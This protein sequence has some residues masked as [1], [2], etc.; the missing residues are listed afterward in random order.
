MESTTALSLVREI[1]QETI[2]RYG[3]INGDN[4]IIHYDHDYA[5]N[6]GFPGTLAH[7]LMVMGY[8]AELG[9]RSL[10]DD[11]YTAGRLR[12]KWVRPVCPGDR[13][14]VSVDGDGRLLAENAEEPVM[15]GEIGRVD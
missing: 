4:D 13:I 9:A 14:T 12:V 7:G 6:R 5:V 11:W 1:T 8:A 10:G 3:E 15:V 2:D